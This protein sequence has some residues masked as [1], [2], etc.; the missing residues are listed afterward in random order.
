M[1]R[2]WG[3][4]LGEIWGLLILSALLGLVAG[5]L[6]WSRRD[7]GANGVLAQLQADLDQCR[8]MHI[9]KDDRIRALEAEV[10]A[11]RT[12]QVVP[13]TSAE[14]P[15]QP[16]PMR[17]ARGGTP[18][19]LKRIRGVGPKLEKLCNELGFFYFDQIAAWTESE[20]AWVDENLKGFKG[21]VSRDRWVAQSKLLAEP[22]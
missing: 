20:V 3:F 21:R 8:A 17:L 1:F 5:W 18:D 9:D 6:I 12:P 16:A 2:D 15:S 7:T 19:D 4:L 11:L 14:I 22:T 10:T 13:A